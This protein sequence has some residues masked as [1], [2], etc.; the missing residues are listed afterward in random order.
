[1]I[2]A[3][4]AW[5]GICNTVHVHWMMCILHRFPAP[6]ENAY[7]GCDFASKFVGRTH[8]KARDLILLFCML[9][10][11]T[12]SGLYYK[13]N[14]Y[15]YSWIVQLPSTLLRFMCGI[16]LATSACNQLEQYCLESSLRARV[17]KIPCLIEWSQIT[18]SM[19]HFVIQHRIHDI[20]TDKQYNRQ[21]VDTHS[22]S[23]ILEFLVPQ[24]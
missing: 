1:M 2:D 19:V 16:H 14:A 13:R 11:C 8:G 21:W 23:A 12:T 4:V 5:S 3:R 22:S 18:L 24:F 6:W 17:A 10:P 15:I 9:H 20:S 7:R